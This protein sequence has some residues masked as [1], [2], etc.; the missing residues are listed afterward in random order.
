MER[1]AQ[2]EIKAHLMQNSPEFRKLADEHSMY[3]K[4]VSEFEA[5]PF[6]T[7]NEEM[8]EQRLKKLK[9]RL[10]DQMEEMIQNRVQ[11]A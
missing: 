8:E 5:K 7:E 11:H 2:E 1:N 4:L 3:K 9:L 6:L 10:K